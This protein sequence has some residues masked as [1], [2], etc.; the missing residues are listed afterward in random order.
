MF[1]NSLK[2]A[3]FATSILVHKR[4]S[5]ILAIDEDSTLMK[6]MRYSTLSDGKRIRPFLTMATAQIFGV[7]PISSLEV[8]VAIELIH[9]YSLVH[10]DLPS[11]DN[12]DYRRGRLSCHKKFNESTA[13]LTG[14]A[15]LTVAFEILADDKSHKDPAIRCEIIKIISKASGYRGM[16]GGQML[17]LENMSSK[18]TKEKLAKIHRLKTGSLFAACCEVGATLGRASPS[19][20]KSLSYFAH[21]LGLAFQIKDDILDHQ[22]MPIGK[23]DLDENIHKKTQDN[24]DNISIVDVLGIENANKQLHMLQEQ[25]ITHLKIFGDKAILLIALCEFINKKLIN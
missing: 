6:A 7:A 9:S 14:D 20:K 21:D 8:A 5:E 1:E 3:I 22:G 4:I 2:E 12:D 18:I 10:D 23:I 25:A 16:V 11:M 13:V 19:E 17:D 15:L 24:K